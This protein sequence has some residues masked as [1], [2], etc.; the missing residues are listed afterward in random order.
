VHTDLSQERD[1]QLVVA[2][3]EQAADGVIVLTLRDPA[4]GQLPSWQPGAHVDLILTPEITRQYSLCGSCA[5]RSCYRIGVLRETMGR[6]GSAYLHEKALAGSVVHVRGP[7]N[8]FPLAPAAR[9]LFIG[10]GIGITPLIPMLAA[11]DAAGTDW[12][13]AYGGRNRASMAFAAELQA[14]YPGRVTI[15]PQ[16]ETGLLDLETMLAQ[17]RDDLLVYCCGPEPLLAAVEARCARWPTGALHVERFSPRPVGDPVLDTAFEVELRIS[18]KTVTVPVGT[19]ILEAVRAAGVEV[20]SAC[21]EGT[22]GTCE[23][24]VLEGAIDHRDSLLTPADRAAQNTMMICV[25][26]AACPRLVLRL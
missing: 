1:L 19:S 16:D 14:G 2:A 25:S 11:A 12:R 21:S 8:N 20:L 7:R 5:D 9:Y 22:C 6:G 26:R 4:G 17:P 15:S 13:L 3:R 10:G 18:Q 24:A 23:T